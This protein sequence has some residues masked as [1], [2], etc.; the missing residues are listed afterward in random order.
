M[1]TSKYIEK[2]LELK[3]K[4]TIILNDKTKIIQG[5]ELK[6]RRDIAN[7]VN[8]NIKYEDIQSYLKDPSNANLKKIFP[9]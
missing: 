3:P 1:K 7:F 9:K 5:V 8:M 2:V 4:L 6:P